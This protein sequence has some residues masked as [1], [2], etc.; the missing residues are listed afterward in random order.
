MVWYP[1][2]WNGDLKSGVRLGYRLWRIL[3]NT[4]ICEKPLNSLP[5]PCFEKSHGFPLVCTALISSNQGC[6]VSH[7]RPSHQSTLVQ[8][9]LSW[10]A[11]YVLESGNPI[12]H[13]QITKFIYLKPIF[14]CK[15]F[16]TSLVNL[17]SR[18]TLF[19]LHVLKEIGSWPQDRIR[20][21]FP[22][23]NIT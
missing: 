15:K 11:D 5:V 6:R 20:Q 7:Q 1:H 19:L 23:L 16:K 12:R 14:F 10:N 18:K 21:T 2:T 13:T 22:M 8:Q 9:L 17:Q 4:K 3:K